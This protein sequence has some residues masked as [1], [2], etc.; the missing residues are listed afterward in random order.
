MALHRA[1]YLLYTYRFPLEVQG[2]LVVGPN[3]TFL[4]Y[5]DQVLPSLGETGVE[6]STATGLYK[7]ARPVAA[8]APEVAHLKGDPRMAQFIRRAVHQRERPL[9]KTAEIPYG[10]AVL[11]LTPGGFRRNSGRRTAPV[12]HTQRPSPCGRDASL[13]A[14]R[15]SARTSC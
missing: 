5:I 14:S 10:R 6:L 1:A 9:R 3:P 12:W 11:T 13:G 8:E 4:R 15:R 7:R 2:V